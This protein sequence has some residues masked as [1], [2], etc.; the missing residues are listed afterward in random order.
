M[1]FI[2]HN[3]A[4]EAANSGDG[5]MTTSSERV[6][7]LLRDGI[8]SGHFQA[9]EHLKEGELAERFGVSRTPVRSAL[10][11]LAN[12][13]F[14]KLAA[15]TGAV[16]RGY[17]PRDMIEIFEVRALLEPH[18]ARL[19]ATNR[20]DEQVERLYALCD[21]MEALAGL[22]ASA[23]AAI[24]PLNNEFHQVLL[25]AADQRHLC[26]VAKSLIE[27][28]MVIRS[29]REFQIPDLE[30]SFAEHRQLASAVEQRQPELA[31]GL[32]RAHI[33]AARANFLVAESEDRR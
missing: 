30:R 23:V 19:A 27:L 20:T 11:R 3:E 9:G 18:A 6:Y 29:Y 12:D 21:R 14:A 10:Q 31:E 26:L 25:E 8:A 15:H 4:G 1:G 33:Y 7:R 2:V 16:V 17:S 28:N 22:Q 24:A 32:M 13:G 5:G